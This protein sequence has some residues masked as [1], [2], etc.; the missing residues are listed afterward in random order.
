MVDSEKPKKSRSEIET[1]IMFR[2]KIIFILQLFAVLLIGVQSNAQSIC[3]TPD[4]DNGSYEPLDLSQASLASHPGYYLTVYIHIIRTSSGTGGQ[5][6]T[7]PA[8]VLDLLNEDF[9]QH[10]IYFRWDECIDFID[11]DVFYYETS[12]QAL[13]DV[14]DINSHD[15]GID[16]YLFHDDH[17]V[18]GGSTM[19][20][21][22]SSEFFV[23]G[24]IGEDPFSNVV[25]TKIVSHEM[26]HVL[27]LLHTHHGAEM[28]NAENPDGTD[29]EI[30]GDMLCDTPADPDLLGYVSFPGCVWAED[31]YLPIW[32]IELYDPDVELI[33]S[34]THPGCMTYFSG[35]QVN[36]MQ[37]SIENLAH[38]QEAMFDFNDFCKGCS[39]PGLTVNGAI[40]IADVQQFSD[41]IIV[42]S[43]SQLTITGTVKMAA[44]K[45]IIVERGAKLIVDGGHITSC[46]PP[47]VMW[48][49]IRVEGNSNKE[50]PEYDTPVWDLAQ[51]DAGI[52][53]VRNE[54]KITWARTA[55]STNY[56][57]TFPDSWTAQ[58]W[59]GLIHCEGAV[60][61][62]NRRVAEFAKYPLDVNAYPDIKN[63]SKFIGCTFNGSDPA[64]EIDGNTV[65][66]SIWATDGV[67]FKENNMFLGMQEAGIFLL[68]SEAK[69]FTENIFAYNNKGIAA[70]SSFI[71]G[72]GLK[73]Y[74]NNVF[75]ENWFHI[76]SNAA[77]DALTDGLEIHG[78]LFNESNSS[79]WLVGPSSFTIAEN[80]INFSNVGIVALQ[81]GSLDFT[82][83][84]LI[85]NNDFVTRN[86]VFA[87]GNNRDIE[88]NCNTFNST[89]TFNFYDISVIEAGDGTAGEIRALQG[90]GNEPADNCF[91]DQTS[92]SNDIYTFGATVPFDYYFYEEN[93]YIPVTAGNYA[94][95]PSK[96]QNECTIVEQPQKQYS[97]VEFNNL[98]DAVNSLEDKNQA[99]TIEYFNQLELMEH[100]QQSLLVNYLEKN[101]INYAVDLLNQNG[102][103]T[104]LLKAFGLLV[105]YGLYDAADLALQRLDRSKNE[106]PEFIET[107]QI[108]LNRLRALN[109]YELT[110]VEFDLLTEIAES[111][112]G[113]KAFA[114]T[115]LY[116]L[117]GID[118][119]DS[120]EEI[121][122]EA[123]R[124]SPNIQPSELKLWPNPASDLVYFSLQDFENSTSVNIQ[125]TDVSGKVLLEKSIAGNTVK[126]QLDISKYDTGIYFVILTDESGDTLSSQKL[127]I[128]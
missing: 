104:A 117:E 51:D 30:D 122:K 121:H 61:E 113:V 107:Q 98:L 90:N 103:S 24:K 119:T 25:E 115:I 17:E 76:E 64:D 79:I 54:G 124:T 57:N 66:V 102:S 97:L 28:S 62:K 13:K 23:S 72:A 43:G 29:C 56:N 9:N 14:F 15:D 55:I 1:T 85:K 110:Q 106:M 16:I 123:L 60:F 50:Q 45:S 109:N 83:H 81:T 108:N 36:K 53:W 71:G 116:L 88:L 44:H 22:V 87:F 70:A 12:V 99:N 26:G 48:R 89:S 6:V 20:P 73:A 8:E 5:P 111:D 3:H 34:Y 80:N 94:A 40:E 95:I 67:E 77:D 101:E 42:T 120:Y 84:N 86:G 126:Q 68:D 118:Y 82:N 114:R 100:A 27:N 39:T 31:A 58:K 69:V 128:Q 59:G 18:K 92:Q 65:G 105:E 10:S 96:A 2:I 38:L 11:D 41:H 52:V 46:N 49:G 19:G 35:E 125:L 74:D 112:L 78:N 7:V 32:P 63:K 93:C 4:I 33:M 21:G 127:I 37:W 47:Y 75:L 91:S